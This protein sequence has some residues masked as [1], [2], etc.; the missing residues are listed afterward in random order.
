MEQYVT[1]TEPDNLLLKNRYGTV[2]IPFAI[3]AHF[4]DCFLPS[5]NPQYYKLIC[6]RLQS[7]HKYIV[8]ALFIWN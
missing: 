6:G 5:V 1:L 2:D 4:Q 7:W 3:H 8:Q